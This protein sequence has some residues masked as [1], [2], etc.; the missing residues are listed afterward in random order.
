ML[1]FTNPPAPDTASSAAPLAVTFRNHGTHGA[2]LFFEPGDGLV[3]R[4]PHGTFAANYLR[5]LLLMFL[6]LALFAAIGVT[7]GTLFSMPV[8]AFLG[9]VLMLVLQLS[10][11]IRAA[12]QADRQTFVANVAAFG[13]AGHAHDGDSADSLRPPGPPAPWPTLFCAYRGTWLALRPCSITAPRDDLAAAAAS[14]ATSPA[15]CSSRDCSCPASSPSSPPPSSTNANGHCL[16]SIK[17]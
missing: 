4:R 8:A 3:L 17:N 16:N 9:L 15:P 7:L 14:P 10:G 5:A 2:T 13:Q 11:F 12:A 6:R 1:L